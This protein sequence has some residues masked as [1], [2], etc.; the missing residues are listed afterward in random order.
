MFYSNNLG[1]HPGDQIVEYI[2]PL[3][4]TKHF[5]IYLGWDHQGTEWII[6]NKKGQAVRLVNASEFFGQVIKIDRIQK[7]TGNNTDRR[8]LVE[9]ALSKIGQPYN[10]INYN[11]EHF[12]TEVTTGQ[13]V[14]RQ[15]QNAVGLGISIFLLSLLIKE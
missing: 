9:R 14:S 3:G 11:C 8:K 12:V 7:Y 13:A 15:V 2:T 10:L 6:E 4:I 5:A 1:L